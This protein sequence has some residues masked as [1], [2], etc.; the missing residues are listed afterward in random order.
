MAEGEGERSGAGME[1]FRESVIKRCSS[2]SS[3]STNTWK[4]RRRWFIG[5]PKIKM[6]PGPLIGRRFRLKSSARVNR[7]S[8]K[9]LL[10]FFLIPDRENTGTLYWITMLYRLF[11]TWGRLVEGGGIEGNTRISLNFRKSS[12]PLIEGPS[13]RRFNNCINIIILEEL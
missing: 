8:W 13:R 10:F 5:A 4:P 7:R 3:V 9:Q 1:R 11:T 12:S 2:P 6:I